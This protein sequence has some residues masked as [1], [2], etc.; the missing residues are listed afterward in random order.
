VM[1]VVIIDHW[2]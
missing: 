1:N 2:K